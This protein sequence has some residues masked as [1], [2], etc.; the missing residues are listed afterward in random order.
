LRASSD[1]APTTSVMQQALANYEEL[2]IRQ[3]LILR[4]VLDI[5]PMEPRWLRPSCPVGGVNV[6]H[7]IAESAC[8]VS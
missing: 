8:L 3:V 6:C 5:L 7:T 1:Q 2:L 4:L